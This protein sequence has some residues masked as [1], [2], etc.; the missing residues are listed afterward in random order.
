MK[1]CSQPSRSEGWTSYPKGSPTP[2]RLFLASEHELGY[3][4]AE[5]RMSGSSLVSL[6]LLLGAC[7]SVI[8]TNAPSA[9]SHLPEANPV[10]ALQGT[11][12]YGQDPTG[13]IPVDP[14]YT[15]STL[16]F[17]ADGRYAFQLGQTRIALEGTWIMTSADGDLLLVHTEYGQGRHNDLALTLRRRAS[18]AT[19][20]MEVREGDGTTAARYYVPRP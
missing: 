11:W 2:H 16:T 14:I 8:Q 13:Q 1:S 19:I 4:A 3:V 9:P 12:I 17:G 18:G 5:G 10:N 6:T 20:G 15:D 7:A